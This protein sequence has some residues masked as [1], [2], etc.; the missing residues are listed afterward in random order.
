MPQHRTQHIRT[1]AVWRDAARTAALVAAQEVPGWSVMNPEARSYVV[2]LLTSAW[3][4]G[5]K[6]ALDR[7]IAE[8][9]ARRLGDL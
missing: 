9:K 4:E 2:N 1:S 8:R 6:F 5:A 7:E 3:L